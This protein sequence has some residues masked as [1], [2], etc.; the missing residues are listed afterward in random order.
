M[1]RDSA[2][3]TYK[4]TF[5]RKYLARGSM[6]RSC[7]PPNNVVAY[8]ALRVVVR[9]MFRPLAFGKDIVELWLCERPT[10]FCY[11]YITCLVEQVFS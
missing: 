8:E 9:T 11:T 1:S 10:L 5:I 6:K 4:I 3:D 2:D 7:F